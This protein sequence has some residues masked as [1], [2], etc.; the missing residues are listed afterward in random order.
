MLRCETLLPFAESGLK[1]QTVSV[2][3]SSTSNQRAGSQGRDSSSAG[4][5]G[6][7]Q[8]SFAVQSNG[9]AVLLSDLVTTAADDVALHWQIENSSHGVLHL[10]EAQLAK[11]TSLR[12]SLEF[13][14]QLFPGLAVA[15]LQGKLLIAGLLSSGYAFAIELP[16]SGSSNGPQGIATA[17]GSCAT[18]VRGMEHS[19]LRAALL[20]LGPRS[21]RPLDLS[22]QLTHLGQPTALAANAEALCIGTSSGLI[23][24]VPLASLLDSSPQTAYASSSGTSN[25]FELRDSSWGLSKLVAEVLYKPRNPS[26]VSLIPITL[27]SRQVLLSV[28]DDGIVRG[29]SPARKQHLF[30]LEGHEP[31]AKTSIVTY[32]AACVPSGST[33]QLVLVTQIEAKETLARRAVAYTFSTSSASAKPSFQSRIELQLDQLQAVH[34]NEH[35]SSGQSL[36]SGGGA[37][38]SPVFTSALLPT[39]GTV[40]D[41]K[42]SSDMVWCLVRGIGGALTGR[43]CIGGFSR[44]SG[45]CSTS[46][47]LQDGPE[48]GAMAGSLGP[49]EQ[50][51]QEK[52]T[53]QLPL[54]ACIC[55]FA[56]HSCLHNV[57]STITCHPSLV[58]HHLHNQCTCA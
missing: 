11:G 46:C 1:Q 28:H 53:P 33:D 38:P 4:T 51:G 37:G 44:S 55:L 52:H 42:A 9:G 35:G 8:Y 41:A 13:G 5:G 43:S 29:W 16:L 3:W 50:V 15:A 36:I 39:S 57:S 26:I 20:G 31:S 34:T 54:L 12:V 58:I 23:I 10:C 2:A 22:A 32:A 21:V 30:T 18:G 17:F 49:V 45:A 56:L 24:C 48:L 25:V 27:H 19:S 14:S 40:V 6:A 47:M 7:Q